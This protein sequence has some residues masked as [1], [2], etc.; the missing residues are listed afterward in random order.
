MSSDDL[1]KILF[2]ISVIAAISWLARKL[3]FGPM[4]VTEEHVEGFSFV[5]SLGFDSRFNNHFLLDSMNDQLL[6]IN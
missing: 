4:M 5:G 2:T 1:E 3:N 6:T